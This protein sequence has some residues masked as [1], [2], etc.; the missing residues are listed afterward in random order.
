MKK[1]LIFLSMLLIFQ[2]SGKSMSDLN[3]VSVNNVKVPFYQKELLQSMIFAEKAEYRAQLLYG[4]NVVINMLQKNV[5]PDRILDDWKLNAYPLNSSLKDLAR[6]WDQRGSYCDAVIFT[7]ESALNQGERSAASDKLVKLR[8]PLIDLD[9][10]GFAADFKRRQI[11][12]NSNVRMILRNKECDPRS[13]KLPSEYEFMEGTSDMLHMDTAKRRIM[14]LGR[15]T[16]LDKKIKLTCDRLT[17][18]LGGGEK[19]GKGKSSMDFSGVRTLYADGNVK[20]EKRLVEGAP[21]EDAQELK[22]DHLVYDT[23]K[24]VLTVTGDRKSP[25]ITSGKGFLLRGKSLVFFR[26]KQQ[27]I[28]PADCWMRIDQKGEKYYILSDYGNFNFSTGLCDFLG[29]VRVSSPQNE[30]ACAK[31][32]VFLEK[33]KTSAPKAQKSSA[34]PLA[35]T[36]D[37]ETGSMEF[38]RALCRGNVNIF[39]REGKNFSTLRSGEADLN[40]DQNKALFSENV[41]C[42]SGGNT[43]TTPRLVVN[44]TSNAANPQKREIESAEALEHVKIV[45]VSSA[46]KPG[47]VLTADSG[48]FDYKAD[49]ID[50]TGNVSSSSGESRLT[51]CKLTLY[52]AEN[53]NAGKNVSV[54][55]LAAGAAGGSKTLKHV[56]A[57]GNAVMQD[58]TNTL[59]GEKLEYFFT[60]A[61]PGSAEQ[62]GLFQ[63]GGLRLTKVQ[64]EGK[65]KVASLKKAEP[66]ISGSGEKAAEKSA[67]A[68][69]MLGRNGGFRELT[70]EKLDADFLKQTT[71]F[72]EKVVITDGTS[73]MDCEKLELFTKVAKGT[74]PAEKKAAPAAAADPDADP[75]DLP[76]ENAVPS[77]IAL[78]NGVELEKAIASENVIVHRKSAPEEKGEKVYC[79]RA[80]FN[81]AD[82]TIECTSTDGRRPYAEGVGRTHTSD[83]F[84]IHLKDERIESSGDAVTR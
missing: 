42:V 13:K 11:K 34:S 15:V 84:T 63:S 6:F 20:V 8:S 56:V 70:A 75:F 67:D 29:R 46:N 49:R 43:L 2:L 37:L 32:R 16:I 26:A 41:R 40:F 5:N 38:K 44:L 51:C 7:P 25:E 59:A 55:G 22:G 60:P 50:F 35:G 83:K 72:S 82:M 24:G 33:S 39:R 9:G 48:F 28:I 3:G 23:A 77:T 62:P 71:V 69:V 45:S 4:H 21:K 79:D 1:G 31:M 53:K 12:V 54:P 66:Q 14:L 36:G 10:V 17:V 19:S 18:D 47:S 78:G 73:R 80:F 81:S 76:S 57:S 61:A 74:S 68:G 52:L 27:L 30:L 65:V 58:K 64:G